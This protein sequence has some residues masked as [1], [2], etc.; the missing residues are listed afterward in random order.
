MEI[1]TIALVSVGGI[2]LCAIAHRL[3]T[4]WNR[5]KHDADDEPGIAKLEKQTTD[6]QTDGSGIAMKSSSSASAGDSVANQHSG[7]S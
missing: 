7:R 6:S 3:A 2:A 1:V 5:V 4:S